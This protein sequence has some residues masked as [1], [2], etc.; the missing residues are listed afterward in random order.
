VGRRYGFFGYE[1]LTPYFTSPESLPELRALG[2][3]TGLTALGG[4][5]A[6]FAEDLY[7]ILLRFP[8]ET[9]NAFEQSWHDRTVAP[10]MGREGP[11]KSL[12]LQLK[13]QRRALIG[14]PSEQLGAWVRDRIRR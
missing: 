14:Q 4:P 12:R 8:G 10:E 13:Q 3:Q 9:T 6:H 1:L 2:E 11:K 5:D 7:R